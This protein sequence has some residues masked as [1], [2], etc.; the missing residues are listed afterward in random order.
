MQLAR[1]VNGFR[2][3][4]IHGVQRIGGGLQ[5]PAREVQIDDGVPELDVTEQ[6][7]N[8]AQVSACF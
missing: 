1:M 5:V 6:Q 8:G 2:T 3:G 7:L 4:H